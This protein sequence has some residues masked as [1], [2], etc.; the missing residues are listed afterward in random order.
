MVAVA[1]TVGRE[2]GLCKGLAEHDGGCDGHSQGEW[3][4][5]LLLFLA[6]SNAVHLPPYLEP[7]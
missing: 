2:L 6:E 3:M 7:A 5:C 4:A 1:F